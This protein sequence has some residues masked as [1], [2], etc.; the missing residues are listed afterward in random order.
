MI[1]L[2]YPIFKRIVLLPL[3]LFLKKIGGIEN[4]PKKG[5]F[6]VTSN[7]AS[8]LDPWLIASVIIPL[9]NKKIH[10][11]AKK[12]R[13]WDLSGDRIARDYFGLVLLE[14]R[15]EE[16][17][18]DILNLLKKGSIVGILI[19]GDRS[20]DGK[21]KKGKTGVAKLALEAKVPILP[22]GLV[23]TYDIAPGKKL[24]PKLRRA[25]MHIGKPIYLNKYY[26]R[27]INEKLLRKLTN[28]VMHVISK[29]SGKPYTH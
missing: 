18:K 10:Y 8:Y 3:R 12:G 29:L 19:E 2:V 14:G 6:I 26:K 20:S 25:K 21:L 7:Y 15:K 9:K 5:P 4:I 24:I 11:L 13:F 28:D 22:I 17:F 23:G 1:I 16:A 27:D